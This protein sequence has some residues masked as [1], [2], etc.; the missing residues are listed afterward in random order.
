MRFRV[1]AAS[2][3]AASLVP[4]AAFA[5]R[6]LQRDSNGNTTGPLRPIRWLYTGTPIVYSQNVTGS[7]GVGGVD[8][9]ALVDRAFDTWETVP[10]AEITFSRGA[11]SMASGFD[12]NGASNVSYGDPDGVLA[13]GVLAAA[14]SYSGAAGHNFGGTDYYTIPEA[15]IVFNDGVD[16]TDSEG[17]SLTSGCIPNATGRFDA[18]SIALHEIG[19]FFGLGHPEPGDASYQYHLA[20]MYPAIGDCD[21]NRTS[22]FA[23]DVDAASFLYPSG[24]DPIYP[25]F[26]LD[27]AKGYLPLQVTFTDQTAGQPP[28]S[29][30]WE[31][32]DGGTATGANPTHEYTTPGLYA[33]TLRVNG[34]SG[35]SVT[36]F[37]VVEAITR[38]EPAFEADVVSGDAPLDVS[39]TNLTPEPDGKSFRWD[40]GDGG[41]SA[42]RNPSHTYQENGRYTVRLRAN[43]GA[44][45]VEVVRDGY[46]QVGPVEKEDPL[47]CLCTLQPTTPRPS[48]LLCTLGFALGLG[49]RRG[50]IRIRTRSS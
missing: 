9:A 22:P 39:F 37:D 2:F 10:S 24:L 50:R 29:W 27:P 34:G 48:L 31:F 4:A 28:T 11:D 38:P 14:V 36:R 41:T 43:G 19:H 44:G 8:V 32:G 16:F 6:I 33:V 25:D 45:N 17:A 40:F 42:A 13:T 30:S 46:I 23:D 21:P 18:E 47:A 3:V 7:T 26:S 5:Y 12:G 35:P 20:I 49:F 15:D 1:F